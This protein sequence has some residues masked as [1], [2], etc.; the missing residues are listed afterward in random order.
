METFPQ[1]INYDPAVH[2]YIKEQYVLHCFTRQ[3]SDTNGRIYV[4]L[5]TAATS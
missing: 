3:D 4:E 2:A 1:L 5:D